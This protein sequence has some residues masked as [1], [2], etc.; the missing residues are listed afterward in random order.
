MSAIRYLYLSVIYLFLYLP[1]AVVILFSFN[2]SA[3]SLLWH[4]FSWHWYTVLFSDAS[5]GEV[6]WHSLLLGVSAASIATI[7]GLFAAVSLFRYRFLGRQWYHGM[8]FLLIVLPDIVI[9]VSMLLLFSLTDF[10]LGF[11]SLWV[12]HTTL[13]LPFACVMISARLRSLDPNLIEAAR[14]LGASELRLYRQVLIPLLW[15]SLLAGWL[16][17]FTLS[18]DDLMISY[19]VSGPDFSILP[20]KIFAMI[21]LGANPEVNALCSLLLLATLV[22]VLSA[23]YLLRQR[24]A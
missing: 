13:C 8:I 2:Q 18:L 11:W 12:A 23:Q 5:M 9:G 15:P 20:L 22:I 10:P 7:L 16:L 1:I 19:F 14:D 17:S 3:H 4:G 21:R 6:A 24:S